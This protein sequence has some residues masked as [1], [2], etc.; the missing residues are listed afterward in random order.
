MTLKELLFKLEQ[1]I[2]ELK[3]SG[4]LEIYYS[5]GGIHGIHTYKRDKELNK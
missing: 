2:K 5:Q 3:W 4:K 1:K